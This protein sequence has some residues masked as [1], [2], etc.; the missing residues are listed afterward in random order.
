MPN[1]ANMLAPPEV[2]WKRYDAASLCDLINECM[3]KPVYTRRNYINV[4]SAFDTE[5]S[6]FIDERT[7][8]EV[9]L[10][11]VWM[12]GIGDTVVY[13]R[14]L[15]EFINLCHSLNAWLKREKKTLISYIHFTKYDFSFIK[16]LL[17]WKQVFLHK[18]RY[19]LYFRYGNIEFRDSLVLAGGRSLA[20]CGADL[21]KPVHKAVGDLDYNLIR[22]P[23][24]PLTPLEQHYCE[25]DIR[26]LIAYIREKI[27]DE[28]SIDKIPYT[29]TG[30]VRRYVKAKC[31]E[32]REHYLSIMDGLTLT[33]DAY[34]QCEKAF[35]GG[36]VGPNIHRVGFVDKDRVFTP[37]V[38]HDVWSYDI[39]SSYP[40][41]MVTQYYPMQY[42]IPIPDKQ[43][44]NMLAHNLEN[45]CCLFTLELFDVVG[46]TNYCFPI[47]RH[48]CNDCI[49]E[50]V[51]S[52]RVLSA[53]YISINVTEL[54][55][56]TIMRFYDAEGGIRVSRFRIFQR[57]RLPQPIVESVIKFFNDKTTLDGIP[58]RKADYMIS[59]NM[60]NAC[61]GMMVEKV[62]R[63]LL[64]FINGEGF[65][66]G[67]KDYVKQIDEYN[68]KES[69]FLYYPWGV[70][71]TAWARYRLYDAIYHVGD[72][73]I[74]CDTDSVK[75]IN[76]EKHVDYFK[77]ANMLAHKAIEETANMLA[78]PIDYIA[79]RSPKGEQKWLGVWE[80]EFEA[81][82]FQTL[83]A[84][85]YLVQ[86]DT[87][88]PEQDT[89]YRT[90]KKVNKQWVECSFEG[91]EYWR[92]YAENVPLE[93]T[94]AGSNKIGTLAY[95]LKLAD[96][97][98]KDVFDLFTPSLVIPAEYAKRTVAKFIDEER[99]G[100][101]TDY[102]GNNYYYNALSGVY[103]KPTGYSFS[104]TEE[105][106]DAVLS[107]SHD[108]TYEEGQIE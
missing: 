14:E 32:N 85:R 94:V 79:P 108:A 22:H 90:H 67:G 45:Y 96:E 105:M 88:T 16:Y 75:L 71:V 40:Y 18:A 28:G 44:A 54:D 62:V 47:S 103:I 25:M 70:W 92:N 89:F 84:K 77:T 98:G 38:F 68:N 100:Y 29:N 76:G 17:P 65:V 66:S 52:G 33:P 46:R 58:D 27:E 86:Y 91:V 9:G 51:A 53:A 4:A 36:A 74:Y 3:G 56:E 26:V 61:Y 42:P 83:G 11:Y 15:P 12:F 5:A 19:P 64:D 21:R 60:L 87:W 1:S 2:K 104:I 31:F 7:E 69:R 73:Y 95:M 107:L 24:T 82:R 48:K 102:L 57:G 80:K 39:K 55:F 20:K 106:L 59:K 101:V 30:Y 37:K 34:L 81:V 13:G 23:Q 41:V 97:T 49:G 6:S 35:A 72:D 50:V 78:M 99:C 93:L 10:C 8:L 63:A 43:A